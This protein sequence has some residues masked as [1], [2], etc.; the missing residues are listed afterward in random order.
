MS[1]RYP[2]I[3]DVN[4]EVMRK[5]KR[6]V[7]VYGQVPKPLIMTGTRRVLISGMF[8][9]NGW[10][11]FDKRV[12]R[13]VSRDIQMYDDRFIP[14]SIVCTAISGCTLSQGKLIYQLKPKNAINF[15]QISVS[16]NNYKKEIIWNCPYCEEIYDNT[17]FNSR[18]VF[19]DIPTRRQYDHD[20]EV[21]SNINKEILYPIYIND[22]S[23]DLKYIV[24]RSGSVISGEP[25]LFPFLSKKNPYVYR[26]RGFQYLYANIIY[27]YS[28]ISNP[29]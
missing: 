8:N 13:F 4:P 28:A 15:I 25:R 29:T 18:K 17:Y 6:L 22:E 5:A 19:S 20:N 14:N 11:I 7:E 1:R 3:N 23:G 16:D 10:T 12:Y 21:D 2:N 26:W 9:V 24:K 27:N